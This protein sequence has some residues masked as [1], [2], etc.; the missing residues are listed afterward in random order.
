MAYSITVAKGGRAEPTPEK[1][2]HQMTYKHAASYAA[3]VI[4]DLGDGQDLA[5]TVWDGVKE[6]V[7][8]KLLVGVAEVWVDGD[9]Y[10]VK[11]RETA[12]IEAAVNN[13]VREWRQRGVSS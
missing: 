3:K 12:Y 13:A 8:V 4:R 5:M 10:A 9:V 1:P 2:Q 11:P 7:E 6:A